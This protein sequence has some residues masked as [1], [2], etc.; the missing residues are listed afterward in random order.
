MFE[1][2][3]LRKSEGG[4]PISA[5]QLAEALLYYQKVHLIVD[6]GTLAALIRQIGT[7][8]II[9]LLRRKCLSAV[10]CEEMLGTHTEQIGASNFHN[11]VAFT[12]AGHQDVGEL[13]TTA[14]RLQY[15]LQGQG[16][17]R[18]EAQKFAKNFLD[19]VP[20]RKL[21]GD[22]YIRGG[23]PKAA[24]ND[25]LNDNYVKHAIQKY[26][27]VASGGYEVGENLRF[28]VIDSALGLVVF[29]DID[30][31][32]VNRRRML[33]TPAEEALTVAHLLSNMLDARA[34]LELASFYGGDFVTSVTTSAIIQARHEDLL[35]RTNLNSDSR[36]QFTDVILP[37]S[38]SLAE[39]IDSGERS[40]DDFLGLLDRAARFKDWIGGVS[41]DENLIRTY[42]RDVS[43]EE[44]IKRTPAKTLRYVL[45][46]GFEAANPIAGVVAGLFDNFLVEKLMK[47][48]RPN[49]FVDKKL[50]PF[51]RR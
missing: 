49:H 17:P 5:G 24:K 51:I 8:R 12:L 48:W 4:L 25:L 38:P 21:S 46:L 20:V 9:S 31:N 35:R 19:L 47:G 28:E 26:M 13:R 33:Q 50:T 6:R 14:E 22:H 43:S 10:Y 36:E 44:W 2:V 1:H 32:E 39:V 42:L 30:L 3:V 16:I 18:P 7:G 27:S 41:P 45:T 11:Y 15:E 23:I 40:F 37:D 29:T 34:D